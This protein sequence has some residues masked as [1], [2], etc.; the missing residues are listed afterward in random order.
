MNRRLALAAAAISWAALLLAVGA[1]PPSAL[2]T[3]GVWALRGIDKVA[4]AVCYG[5][6]GL[7]AGGAAGRRA[8]LFGMLAGLA[9]GALDEHLQA[10]VAGRFASGW[11]LLAD[12]F[13]GLAGGWVWT[14]S[15]GRRR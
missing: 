1:R 3:G 14:R 11:D 8:A 2:P 12:T 13:G 7:I 6:L 5:I 10:N 15:F 9:C 4:H